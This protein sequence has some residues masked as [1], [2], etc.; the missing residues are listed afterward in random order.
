MQDESMFGITHDLSRISKC[1][2]VNVTGITDDSDK[3]SQHEP[4]G[5]IIDLSFI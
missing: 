2:A 1:L 4:N 3:I 5:N